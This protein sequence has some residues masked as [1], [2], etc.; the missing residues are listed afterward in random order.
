MS[1]DIPVE[2]FVDQFV[3]AA[4]ASVSSQAANGG[5]ALAY[6]QFDPCFT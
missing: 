1:V 6:F 3:E 2:N 4:A 5:S